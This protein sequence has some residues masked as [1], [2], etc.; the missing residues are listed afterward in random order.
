M[1]SPMSYFEFRVLTEDGRRIRK[2]SQQPKKKKGS[3]ND[4]LFQKGLNE[5]VKKKV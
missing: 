4:D 1:E 2:K 3:K 5:G